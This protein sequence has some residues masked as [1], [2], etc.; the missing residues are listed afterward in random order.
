[1][2]SDIY[3]KNPEDPNYIWGKY[4]HS[5]KIESIISKIRMILSTTPGQILGDINFG[6]GIE[7]LVFETRINKFE[8]EDKI[9]DQLDMYVHETSEFSITPKV[10]FG[11][12][13]TYDYCVI[14]FFINN[15]KIFGVLIK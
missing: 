5:D 12:E 11:K 6:I 4:E 1:M 8:L 7:D 15:Q 13:E 3:I 9:R 10:S 14:D 2:I